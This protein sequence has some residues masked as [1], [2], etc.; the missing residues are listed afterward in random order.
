MGMDG[1]GKSTLS[2]YL[3]GELKRRG[4]HVRRVWWLEGEYI[5]AEEAIQSEGGS[6]LLS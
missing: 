5:F 2:S 6:N 1:S 4:H 3:C